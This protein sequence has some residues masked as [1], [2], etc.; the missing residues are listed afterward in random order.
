MA[1]I[2]EIKAYEIL[3][4][5]GNPTVEAEVILADGVVGTASCPSG[6]SVGSYEAVELRDH[7]MARYRGF[8]VLKA[9]ENIE[10]IIAPKL[11][12]MEANKQQEIDKIMIELDGTQNK[13]RLGAN[14]TLP[15]SMAIAK[16][17]AKSS[18]LPLYLYLRQF[19]KRDGTEV[20][21]KIPTPLFNLINGGKHADNSLNFQEFLVIPASSKTYAESIQMGLSIKNSLGDILRTNNLSTLIGDEGGFGPKLPTNFDALSIL[22]QAIDKNPF[23]FGFDVFIGLDVSANNFYH[24]HQ[25]KIRDKAMELSARDLIAYYK[26][27]DKTFHFL[28]LEDP[29]SED[30]WEGWSKIFTELSQNAIIVGDDLTTTNPFRLQMAID[31]KAI[32]GILIKPNQIGTVIEAIAVVEVA[33]AMGLK[34]TVSHRS[35]ETNDDFIADFAVAVLADYVKFGAP[36]RGERVA[37]YNRLFQIERQIRSIKV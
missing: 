35:G 20:T 4:S 1:K 19:T 37:K 12:G 33:R 27:L 7:D 31:K 8:G 23:R 29:L 30:D 13:G 9:V 25:Y 17:G 26:E 2:K 5:R 32:S 11:I 21:L 36:V 22:K 10:K 24:E 16:A 34:I 28:Y 6:A 18:V 14:A 15:V 3:D